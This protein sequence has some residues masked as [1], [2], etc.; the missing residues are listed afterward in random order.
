[1]RT[2]HYRLVVSGEKLVEEM[3]EGV[4]DPPPVTR[5]IA[6]M[7]LPFEIWVDPP[8]G[9]GGR[10]SASRPRANGRM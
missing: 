3:T 4:D 6:E 10:G 2:A 5:T 7:T 8:E 1:V 9:C